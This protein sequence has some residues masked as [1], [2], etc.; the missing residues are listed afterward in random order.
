MGFLDQVHEYLETYKNF[1]QRHEQQQNSQLYLYG[2][3]SPEVEDKAIE[4]M[5]LK[6]EGDNPNTIRSMQHFMSEGSWED[7]P[8]LKHHGTEVSHDLGDKDGVFI[9]DG[10]DFPKQ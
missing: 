9:I 10:N 1:I 3:L 8:I 6:L 5:M 2:L 4:L 7:N